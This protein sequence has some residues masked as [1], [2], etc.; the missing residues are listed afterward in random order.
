LRIRAQLLLV[1]DD[2][3]AAVRGEQIEEAVLVLHRPQLS[4]ERRLEA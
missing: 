2:E 1:N 4:V 3:L